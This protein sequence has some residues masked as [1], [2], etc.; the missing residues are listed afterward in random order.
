MRIV[1]GSLQQESNTLTAL[2]STRGDFTVFKGVEMLSR[3]SVSEYFLSCG[4]ELVPT[5]YANAVPG[6]RLREADFLG[7]AGE[8][9]SLIP[10]SRVDGIWLYLHGALEVENLGSGELALLRLVRERCGFGIPIALALDFHA[11][12]TRELMELVNVV[13]GYRTVP[14]R[15]MEETELRAATMLVNC[16]ENRLLPRP[17]MCRADV[18]VPGDCVLTDESPLREIMEEAASLE[19]Q[20]G[21]LACNVFN[22]QPWVDAPNMG[23]SMVCVHETDESVAKAAARQLAKRFFDVRR[24]FRFTVEACEPG[25]ALDRAWAERERPVFVT[26]SGDNTT[27]GSAGDNAGL[28]KLMQDKGMTEVLL[29]GITDEPAVLKC[30]EAGLGDLLEFQLGGSIEASSQVTRIS[31]LL[32][33]KGDIEGWYGE[34]AGP[35]AVLRSGGIDVIITAKRSALTKPRIFEGLGLKL[36]DYRF[37]VVKLGYLFPDLAKVA[38]HSFLALTRGGST[39]R[40][41]DMGMR[42]IRRPMFPLDDG[43]EPSFE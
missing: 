37:V 13:A 29:G 7:L 5:L 20:Q 28:L 15:D 27:A 43:F 11:N 9:V 35:C 18:V 12:N 25:E 26:D 39:E 3:V 8:L 10:T 19:L 36:D 6:G 41:Q 34:N 30:M 21:M 16:I 23:P 31:G 38:K 33:Y 22:G 1:V 40:L 32:V 42:H 17:Q 14:H 2:P 24:E 4:A